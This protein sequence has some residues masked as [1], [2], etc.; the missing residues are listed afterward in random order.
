MSK[1]PDFKQYKESIAYL[2]EE[3]QIIYLCVLT[4]TREALRFILSKNGVARLSQE[5]AEATRNIIRRRQ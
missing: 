1:M 3:D 5:A 2:V 4:D